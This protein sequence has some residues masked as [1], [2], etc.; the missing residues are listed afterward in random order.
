MVDAVVAAVEGG[1]NLVQLR[2][3]SMSHDARVDLARQ[4]KSAISG[5]AELLI[6]SDIEA[7]LEA[8]ADGIH[9]PEDG[10]DIA[11]IRK[12]IGERRMITQANHGDPEKRWAAEV[13]DVDLL[14]FGTILPTG[15]KPGI[16]TQGIESIGPYLAGTIHTPVVAIGGITEANVTEVMRP[17]LAGIAVIGAIMDAADPRAAASRLFEAIEPLLER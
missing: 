15:S 14:V 1:V 11:V 10:G 12:R 4:L 17:G 8:D 9:L 13:A 5:R 7:V 16:P 6:N 2:E 3:K